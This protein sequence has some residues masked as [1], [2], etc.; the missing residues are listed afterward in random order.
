MKNARTLLYSA[1]VCLIIFFLTPNQTIAQDSSI[2]EEIDTA[3]YEM[4][5][6]GKFQILNQYDSCCFAG[7]KYRTYEDV[8]KK[9]VKD[10]GKGNF[11][12]FLDSSHK[13][14]KIS[15]P[16]L[17]IVLKDLSWINQNQRE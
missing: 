10:L 7:I 14:H 4:E 17:D 5:R 13:E 8:I 11:Q 12:I 2:F 16:V 9:M 15:E 6:F 1:L 3:Y